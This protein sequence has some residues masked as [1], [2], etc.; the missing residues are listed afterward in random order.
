MSFRQEFYKSVTDRKL[1]SFNENTIVLDRLS[2][3]YDKILSPKTSD[4]IVN[5]L[6]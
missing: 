3:L 2:N 6:S 1:I 5:D 4:D